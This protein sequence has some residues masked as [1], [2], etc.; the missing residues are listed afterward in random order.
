M[1]GRKKRI[2]ADG[3]YTDEKEWKGNFLERLERRKT[4]NG[5]PKGKSF[6]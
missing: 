3:E 5:R 4:R 6:M 1:G 2:T